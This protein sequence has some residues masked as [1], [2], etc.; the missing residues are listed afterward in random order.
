MVQNDCNNR[1]ILGRYASQVTSNQ[2]WYTRAAVRCASHSRLQVATTTTCYTFRAFTN[3]L[4]RQQVI[5]MLQ[6]TSSSRSP[7]S[8][9]SLPLTDA[10]ITLNMFFGSSEFLNQ[11]SLNAIPSWDRVAVNTSSSNYM[12]P[13][14]HMQYIYVKLSATLLRPKYQSAL[15]LIRPPFLPVHISSNWWQVTVWPGSR[16]G[17]QDSLIRFQSYN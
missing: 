7:V 17:I 11:L 6:C 5:F 1:K 8:G 14:F 16:L 3:E 10:L 2:Y 13:Y 9:D 12:H 4:A 15:A